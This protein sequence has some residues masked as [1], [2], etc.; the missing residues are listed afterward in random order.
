MSAIDKNKAAL[1]RTLTPRPGVLSIEPYRGGLSHVAGVARTIKLSSNESAI[2]PSPLALAALAKF[3]GEAYRYPDGTS[4]E[5]RRA[6]G[7]RHGLDPA[8]IA[9][10]AGSDEIFTLLAR[11]YAGPGDEVLMSEHG[12]LMFAINA[13]AVGA[14][15]VTAPEKNLCA[16]VEALL[17]RVTPKTRIVFIANPNNPTGSYLPKAELARLHAGLPQD[18][19]LV[20]DG[21]YSEYATP[22]DFS[23]GRELAEAHANAVMTRTFSKIYGLAALRLGWAYCAPEI[24][25]AL[26]RVRNPF[27]VAMT[28]QIAGIAALDDQKHLEVSRANNERWLP[29]TAAELKKL[30]LEVVSSVA[31]FVMVCFPDQPGK[32]ADAAN[33]FLLERGIIVRKVAAYRLPHSLRITI[34]R[35][36]EMR[37]VV[38][39][40]AAFMGRN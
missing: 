34:G 19:L 38:A 30:G 16:D 3:G 36:D 12:F 17:A 11:L 23:A 10:G 27:N 37:A 29:W 21:A 13:K 14:V 32:N 28:A 7:K 6:I 22:A 2:G 25:D 40:L 1:P 26:N 9:C 20:I 31:H 15:L 35:E 33:D 5:L 24:V 8:R 18:V 4:I 39:A